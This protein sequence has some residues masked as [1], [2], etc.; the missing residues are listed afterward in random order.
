MTSLP[1]ANP[2]PGAGSFLIETVESTQLE[3]RRLARLG[4]PPG[5]LVAAESQSAGRGRIPERRWLDEPGRNLLFTILL[6][7]L[8][9]GA[10]ALPL[11]IGAALCRAVE[12]QAIRMDAD[13]GRARP[14]LKWPNDLLLGERKAAGILCEAA[15][16][17]VYAGIGVNVNQRSF[18]EALAA[19]ATSLALELGAEL[20]R[21]A[22][23]EVFLGVLRHELAEADWRPGVE[24][25]LWRRGETVRFVPGPAPVEGAA[26][27]RE[28][29][30]GRLAGVDAEGSLLIAVGPERPR[31]FAAGE[32][33]LWPGSAGGEGRRAS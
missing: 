11:R 15:P 33:L 5:S 8:A 23:L 7:P 17:G 31:A 32:L 2:F 26:E 16:E 20:D 4:F 29:V 24:E 30:E 25:L 13:L 14:R 9:A 18:P 10:P 6:D 28:T 1:I 22:F 19:K 21:W 3:A 27:A 12:I